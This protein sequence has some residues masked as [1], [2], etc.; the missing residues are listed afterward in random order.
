MILSY[1]VMHELPVGANCHLFWFQLWNSRNIFLQKLFWFLLRKNLVYLCIYSYF[2]WRNLFASFCKKEMCMFLDF[3]KP[4]PRIISMGSICIFFPFSLSSTY[5]IWFLFCRFF[6]N[7]PMLMWITI[8]PS[9]LHFSRQELLPPI[10]HH[11]LSFHHLHLSV[12]LPLWFPHQVK[13]AENLQCF[14]FQYL[15]VNFLFYYS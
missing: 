13:K 10:F 8:F 9:P 12:L 1:T 11:L 6:L 7:A 5:N 3:K 15:T 14:I 4:L 2:S